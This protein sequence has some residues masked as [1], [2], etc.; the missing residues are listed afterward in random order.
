MD[1]AGTPP[2][3]EEAD[4][5]N[6]LSEV[7]ETVGR[8]DPAEPSHA[9]EQGGAAPEE[10]G[11]D[12]L[13]A[14]GAATAESREP[15]QGGEER[16][17][18]AHIFRRG[19]AERR[20]GAPRGGSHP[21]ARRQRGDGSGHVNRRRSD[22][23]LP[24]WS[25]SRGPS[26]GR[27]RAGGS[28]DPREGREAPLSVKE[29]RWV[30]VRT[31]FVTIGDD[32]ALI[33]QQIQKLARESE[34]AIVQER[35]EDREREER[36]L[37]LK[38]QAE[39]RDVDGD[40]GAIDE[41]KNPGDAGHRE[42]LDADGA[43]ESQG[44]SANRGNAA[45]AE[46]KNE[47]NLEDRLVELLVDC[48]SLLPLKVGIYSCVVGLWFK[49]TRLR[50]L[51][52]RIVERSFE[53]FEEAVKK[54]N[55]LDA[56]LLLRFFVA[57]A[58]S[59]VVSAAALPWLSSRSWETHRRAVEELLA[60]AHQMSPASPEALLL[61]HATL[62]I[63]VSA[64]GVLGGDEA[65]S[66][67]LASLGL[68]KN[69]V[70][71]LLEAL[72][73]MEQVQWKS[74]AT[75]RFYQ[76]ADLFPLLKP[77]SEA[78]A[79]LAPACSLPALTLTLDDLRQIRA[80]PVASVIR[81][82]VSIE[83]VDVPLS[84]HDRWILEDHFLT[85][86]HNFRDNVTLCAEALLRVPVDHDQFDYVL[87][88]CLFS[89]ML[90][91][92]RAPLATD[93]EDTSFFVTRVFQR[94]CQ[95]QNSLVGVVEAGLTSLLKHAAHL[96]FQSM[97]VLADFFAYWLNLWEGRMSLLEDWLSLS[98]PPACVKVFVRHAFEK[99]FRFRYRPN[100]LEL[101]PDCVLP[102]I[103]PEP[104]PACPYTAEPPQQNLPLPGAPPPPPAAELPLTV[105]SYPGHLEFLEVQKLLLFSFR[106]REG[107]GPTHARALGAG[108][109]GVRDGGAA[110]RPARG[111]ADEETE[112]DSKPDGEEGHEEGGDGAMNEAHDDEEAGQG[113]E[114]EKEREETE[115]GKRDWMQYGL[116]RLLR[117]RLHHKT[118]RK[119]DPHAFSSSDSAEDHDAAVDAS[120]RGTGEDQDGEEEPKASKG[121]EGEAF[122]EGAFPYEDDDDGHVWSLTDLAQ[123]LVFALLARGLKTL[124]HS[125]RLVE[126]YFPVF[127]FLKE[128]ATQKALREMQPAALKARG[129]TREEC[130]EE[131][132]V[133]MDDEEEDEDPA[134]EEGLTKAERRAQ[135]VEEAFLKAV[136]DFWKHSRQK[137]VLTVRHF[138]R[139]G[140]VSKE[141]V[142]RFVFESLSPGDRDDSRVMELF[143]LLAQLSIQDFDVKK[144][145]A[146]QL[147]DACGEDA[148]KIAEAAQ[149]ATAAAEALEG[150]H[151]LLHFI[152]IGFMRELL[153]EEQDARRLTLRARLLY[154]ARDYG[155]FIDVPRLQ[156]QI[157]DSMTDELNQLLTVSS[158]V[159][160]QIFFLDREPGGLLG[161]LGDL[162]ETREAF[163]AKGG[164]NGV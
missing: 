126:N 58:G 85:I 91:L 132:D 128:G 82:P 115:G 63:R 135:E 118:W 11:E 34:N 42:E 59:F 93:V 116:A 50:P 72:G 8:G 92:P 123:V 18:W 36:K 6:C 28:R 39:R 157:G 103:P 134:D 90:R 100:L 79:A 142:I 55:F 14:E 10:K 110:R 38:Q 65:D 122:R 88:E 81:L 68:D 86:L 45:G 35:E 140:V 37:K 114:G 111:D 147:K 164:E 24:P 117:S 131:S 84:P 108:G 99:A 154:L 15:G 159:Q 155:K 146:L 106:K 66:A 119:R 109:R 161:P 3:D 25:Q 162:E 75:L 49:K 148:E 67:I 78:A 51:C 152:L 127:R 61:R 136:F 62:P 57:L 41:L 150:V 158:Q 141:G 144:E 112:E 163:H 102:Y 124:T 107:A 26:G 94:V 95:M 16:G 97:R 27:G 22:R 80:L 87:V 121:G 96:D 129:D 149:A 30:C 44:D 101:L 48:A 9:E 151:T 31:L 156:G 32:V 105:T 76:S 160:T 5:T 54:G 52:L 130:G 2:V 73:S 153:R 29:K 20:R 12:A 53:R 77:P 60:L 23:D 125:E 47:Q 83:K 4:P 143:D 43:V 17:P 104:T 19:G 21:Y 138:E 113:G 145:T 139:F 69:R 137:T 70:Q 133:E 13:E 1:F 89:A 40:F 46:E 7:A 71:S 64:G 98:I 74:K 120:K 33:P 56:K